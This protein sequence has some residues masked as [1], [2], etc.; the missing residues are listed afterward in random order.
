MKLTETKRRTQSNEIWMHRRPPP[1]SAEGV[2]RALRVLIQEGV[3]DRVLAVVLDA[4]KAG[5]L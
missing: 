4:W 1:E 5:A 3:P 2:L